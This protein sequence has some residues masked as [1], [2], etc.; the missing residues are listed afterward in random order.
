VNETAETLRA[1]FDR[2][3]ADAPVAPVAPVDLLVLRA[4]GAPYAV[5]RAQLAALRA[6]LAVVA[7]PSPAPALLGV[8]AQRG[9]VLPVWDLGQLAHG[10]PVRARKW[11]A[12]VRDES[13]A[14]AFDQLDGYV[15]V[16]APVGAA[17]EHAG[18]SYPILDVAGVLAGGKVAAHG[19]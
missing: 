19:P 10:V 18:V 17:V 2:A 5:A 12:I 8:T 6:G 11:Y 9:A 3:F 14:L 15:R 1:A 16:D 7:L 4:G 13:A